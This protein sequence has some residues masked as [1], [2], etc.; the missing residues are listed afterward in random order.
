M[1]TS[2]A[3]S[4]WIAAGVFFLRRERI[5]NRSG[6]A[7][8]LVDFEQVTAQLPEKVKRFHFVLRLAHGGRKTSIR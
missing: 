3:I 6:S 1:A 4:P 7:D 2:R 8:L 5:L